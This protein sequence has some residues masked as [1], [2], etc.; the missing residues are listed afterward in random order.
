MGRCKRAGVVQLV[1][2]L[3]AKVV[4]SSPTSGACW[5]VAQLVEQGAVNAQVAGSSPAP[6]AILTKEN[7]SDT[8]RDTP[9]DPEG[10]GA[11]GE[12][13]YQHQLLPGRASAPREDDGEQVRG[14]RG[15]VQVVTMVPVFTKDGEIQLFDMYVDGVWHGSRRTEAQC[16]LHFDF[17]EGE[18]RR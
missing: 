5:R 6:S 18:S 17:I 14:A 9:G 4:G 7:E 15:E 16:R 10:S 3:Q 13:G 2:R 11:T 12:R 1:E 8:S